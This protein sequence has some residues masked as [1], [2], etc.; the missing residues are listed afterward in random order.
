MS[1]DKCRECPI[2]VSSSPDGRCN[3]LGDFGI[4]F[5]LK[6]CHLTPSDMTAI[7]KAIEE[8][9]MVLVALRSC[10]DCPEYDDSGMYPKCKLG[11]DIGNIL[12]KCDSYEGGEDE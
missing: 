10:T 5:D 9:S 12:S 3:W 1:E 8:P 6:D 7:R 4:D 11:A 2:W